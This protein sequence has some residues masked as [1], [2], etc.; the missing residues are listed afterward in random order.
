MQTTYSL[1]VCNFID[2]SLGRRAILFPRSRIKNS[3]RTKFT[4]KFP[5]KAIKEL[6]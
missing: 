3:E 2:E 1:K 4:F 6:T 5:T